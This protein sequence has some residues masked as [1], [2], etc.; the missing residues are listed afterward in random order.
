V[1]IQDE[2][3]HVIVISAITWMRRQL[4]RVFETNHIMADAA[5]APTSGRIITT[6]YD[7]IESLHAQVTPGE[8]DLV[9]AAMRHIINTQ[10]L[11]FLELHRGHRLKCA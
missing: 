1:L 8:D 2:K 4:M 5:D 9:I 11:T 3:N 10:R 6:L 7:L